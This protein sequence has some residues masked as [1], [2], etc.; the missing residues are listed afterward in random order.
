MDK[1]TSGN[2]NF[3]STYASSYD[4]IYRE[5]NYEAECDFIEALFRRYSRHNIKNILDLGCGTGGH[6]IPLARRGYKVHG[7][8]R[9]PEMVAI[10]KEK[11]R[12]Q[13]LFDRTS[14]EI[15]NIQDINLKN[16][17]DAVICMFAVIGYQ[18]SND[19]IFTTLQTVRKHLRLKGLFIC[20][21]WYGPAVLRQRPGERIKFINKDGERILRIAKP[22]IN[23]KDNIVSVKYHILRLKDDQLIEEEHELHQMRYL[24]K[25]EIEFMLSQAG[26]QLVRLC[27]FGDLEQEVT[28][29]TWNV[30]AIARR[31]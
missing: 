10:A 5:K 11:A 16:K 23:I 12:A 20:D 27:T 13:G 26:M 28:E 22:E 15:S 3:R 9:S 21:F 2:N 29:N 4:L 14:F 19:E 30:T 17:F 31:I 6:A 7:I 8:D 18:T 25:P 1:K 24:F